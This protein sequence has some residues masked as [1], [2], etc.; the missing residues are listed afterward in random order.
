MQ[1]GGAPGPVISSFFGK[2]ASLR[3]LLF[4]DTSEHLFN[5]RIASSSPFF[6]IL[7][8]NGW[9]STAS[10]SPFYEILFN[11]RRSIA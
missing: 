9:R 8:F 3:A 6:D 7:F 5:G 10:S 1:A 2:L 4:H 11:G